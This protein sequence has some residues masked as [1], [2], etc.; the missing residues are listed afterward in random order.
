[1]AVQKDK[2][3]KPGIYKCSGLTLL[4]ILIIL[5]L[6]FHATWKVIALLLIVL[7]ACTILPRPYRKWFWLSVAAVVLVLIIWVFLPEDNEGWRPYTF[8]EELA[9]LEAKYAIPDSENAAKIY[10]QLLEDYNNAEFYGN[11]TEEVQR[12]LPIREPWS[13]Q[14]HPE[15]VDWIKS[16]ES[17]ITRLKEAAA[18]KRCHFN[19]AQPLDER[20]MRKTGM[21]RRWAFLLITAAN[22]DLA[23]GRTDQA[24][25]KLITTLEM[26]K[27][28]SEQPLMTDMLMGIAIEAFA[29]GHLKSFIVYR[30]A[31][32]QRLDAIEQA[33]AYIKL[34]WSSDW[35]RVLE[36]E[37]LIAKNRFGEYY[38]RDMTGR[39]RLSR[40]PKASIRKMMRDVLEK[41]PMGPKPFFPILW[42]NPNYWQRKLIKAKTIL[43]WFYLPSNPKKGAE[44]IDSLYEKYYKRADAD[45]NWKKE[46][47][48]ISPGFILN[49]SYLIERLVLD[50][51]VITNYRLHDIYLRCT[52]DNNVSRLIVTLRRYKNKHGR[53]PESLDSIKDRV[54]EEILVDPINGGSF[55]YKLTEENFTLYSKGKN[56]IDEA[57]ERDRQSGAD[58]WLNWPTSSRKTKNEEADTE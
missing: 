40:D 33:I 47:E 2:N 44:I 7:A 21:V 28:H 49:F 16:H 23:Q 30:D 53:W 9:A 54:P 18:I 55:V 32:E 15:L 52:A 46:P 50:S 45:F 6:L 13:G 11:L 8:D 29:V 26:G 48:E 34:D 17:T 31:T 4:A 1:M 27:H 39:I 58:D 22:N 25:E 5:A 38:E 51:P 36:G 14:E 37:K 19:I 3:K 35:L 10:N 43:Y 20:R 24:L 56:N 12:K 57:G 41:F 42:P